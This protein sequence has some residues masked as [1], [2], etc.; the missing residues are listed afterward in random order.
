MGSH[1]YQALACAKVTLS[2]VIYPSHPFLH[3]IFCLLY[4]QILFHNSE[5][6]SDRDPCGRMYIGPSPFS[7][8]EVKAVAN[9][10]ASHNSSIQLYAAYHSFSQLW[11]LPYSYSDVEVPP[12]LDELVRITACQTA[13]SAKCIEHVQVFMNYV[14]GSRGWYLVML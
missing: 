8:P 4:L 1:V 6:E 12:N 2:S 5:G 14:L 11:M 10:L 9:F 3:I 7:E 13:V